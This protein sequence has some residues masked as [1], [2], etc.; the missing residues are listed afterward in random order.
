[1]ATKPQKNTEATRVLTTSLRTYKK[2][3]KASEVRKT[4][5]PELKAFVARAR[6]LINA[7]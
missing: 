4:A 7:H 5:S 3:A 2:V 6:A 1:M